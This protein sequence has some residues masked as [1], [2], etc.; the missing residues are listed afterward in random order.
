MEQTLHLQTGLSQRMHTAMQVG[1]FLSRWRD[2]FWSHIREIEER[3]LFLKLLS[4]RRREKKALFIS[5]RP[6]PFLLEAHLSSQNPSFDLEELMARHQTVIEKCKK[7]GHESFVAL[8]L[9]DYAYSV[10][11]LAEATGLSVEEVKNFQDQV[12]LPVMLEEMTMPL[13]SHAPH[14]STLEK[15]ALV[16]NED[17]EPRLSLLSERVR[18]RIDEQKIRA[19]IAEQWVTDKEAGELQELRQELEYVNMRLNLVNRVVEHVVDVQRE[20]FL[21]GSERSLRPLEEKEL[22]RLL[23]IDRGWLCRLIQGKSL[24]T[25][26]GDRALPFFF[27]TFRQDRKRKGKELLG[28]LLEEMK[29]RGMVVSDRELAG[30]LEKRHGLGASRRTVNEWRNEIEK[31]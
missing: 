19:L 28:S 10:A 4:P 11:E 9:G 25:P 12:L 22:A 18:Y 7:L 5:P 23:A 8:F 29:T 16:R 21:T 27:R 17:G 1:L 20:F 14:A 13:P 26:R 24:G 30:L 31:A 15:V 3:E 2:N 6:L